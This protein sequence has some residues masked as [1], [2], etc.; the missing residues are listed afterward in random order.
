[1]NDPYYIEKICGVEKII[2]EIKLD[3]I[4]VGDDF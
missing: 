2:S 1:M 4:E 3:E